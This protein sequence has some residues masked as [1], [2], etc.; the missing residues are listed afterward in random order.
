MSL[1]LLA[2]ALLAVVHA[3][4]DIPPC[5]LNGDLVNGSCVCD[6]GWSGSAC[7]TLDLLPAAPLK[8][9][10]Q[11]YYHPTGSGGPVSNSWGITVAKDDTNE[12]LWHGFMTEMKGGC[13]LSSW[14]SASHVLHLTAPQP[15]GPWV[16]EGVALD[17]FAHN[18]QLVRGA[19]G[20]WLLFHIGSPEPAGCEAEVCP[21]P[22][23]PACSGS[24]GTSVARATSPYGPWERLPFILPDN[25]TNPSALVLP[26][27]TIAVT[28][29][30]W[31]GGV[32]TYT[33]QDW[34]GPYVAAPRAPVVLVRAGL[35]AQDTYTPF[36]E[37]PY[38]FMDAHQRGFHM[39][40][41]RQPNGTH[42]PVGPNP[43][44]CDC[45]GGHMYATQLTGPWFVDLAVVYNCTLSVD[46]AGSAGAQQLQISARQRPTL[47]L[48]GKGGVPP[49]CPI[50]FN[51]ASNGPTQYVS[52]FTM[53]Q[54]VDCSS[55]GEGVDKGGN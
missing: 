44:D 22:H 12:T 43:S 8:A 52:S 40:T 45:A 55:Q 14:T 26:D 42:C 38:L 54:S 2:P 5:S 34:R 17:K 47:L 15:L 9:G 4:S 25:E 23:N 39:L 31:E 48:P 50:L 53:A 33:A 7:H 6:P 30:R 29:R 41:H 28:A 37:D 18:P 3:A 19:D 20:S 51:G 13:S 27:G 32:P 49:S 24:Q 1:L 10:S 21:G 36:D 16:V 35:P 11:I 46:S